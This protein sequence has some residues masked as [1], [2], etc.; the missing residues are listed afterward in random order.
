MPIPVFIP[1]KN[2]FYLF[3]GR[4]TASGRPGTNQMSIFNVSNQEFT[5]LD[6]VM[7]IDIEDGYGT[8]FYEGGKI[9]ILDNEMGNQ[10][11]VFDINTEEFEFIDFIPPLATPDNWIRNY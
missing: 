4:T 10:A 8:A 9:F 11:L 6:Y 7:P 2:I 3:G 5:I 1:E